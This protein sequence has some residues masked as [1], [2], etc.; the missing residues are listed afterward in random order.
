MNV[1]FLSLLLMSQTYED[2]IG[3]ISVE[4]MKPNAVMQLPVL[5]WGADAA[6]F[7]ANG[8]ITTTSLS[9]FDHLG[10]NFKIVNGDDFNQQVKDYMGG[11]TSYIRATARM[12]SAAAELLNKDDR[13]KPV[14]IVQLSY[15]LGDHIVARDNIKTLNDLKGKRIAIQLPIGPHLGLIQDSL[16]AA[17]ISI[18]DVVLVP[19]K[20]LSGDGDSPISVFKKDPTI[21]ACCVITPDMLALT[22]GLNSIGNGKE[23]TVKGA[24]VLNSTATMSRSI[25]DAYWVRKDYLTANPDKVEKF[26]VGYL[27]GAEQLVAYKEE[28]KDGRGS[29]P[30]YIALMKTM[31]KFYGESILRL[32]S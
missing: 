17:Q 4:D 27:K 12:M 31:Q 6:T 16:D 18:S 15:S 29:S 21:S 3:K 19:C 7:L 11:K 26:V 30:R 1:V 23:H 13:T 5:T 8:N 14:M 25:V 10:L 22:S 24:H 20:D 9:T 32:S 2:R 28:Y